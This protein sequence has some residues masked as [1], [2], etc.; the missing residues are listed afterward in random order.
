MSHLNRN[1][2]SLALLVAIAL[3]MAAAMLAAGCGGS[4]TKPA[5]APNGQTAQDVA[6]QN[7]GALH[8]TTTN[9][10]FNNYNKKQALFDDPSTILWC[11]YFPPTPGAKPFTVPVSGKLTS[12]TKRATPPTKVLI[13]GYGTGGGSST[14]TPDQP[15]PDGMFGSSDQYRFGFTPLGMYE[16][17]ENLASFCTTDLTDYGRTEAVLILNGTTVDGNAAPKATSPKA[18]P[19]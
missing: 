12:S 7:A 3:A 17:F 18:P 19:K 9:V 1:A 6:A 14:Y 16:D 2:R 15:G 5:A 10:E 4:S 11:T 13:A 8:V